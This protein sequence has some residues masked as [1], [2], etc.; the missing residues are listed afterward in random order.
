[1]PERPVLLIIS[2]SDLEFAVTAIDSGANDLLMSPFSSQEFCVRTGIRGQSA[3]RRIDTTH[4]VVPDSADGSRVHCEMPKIDPRTFRYSYG[5]PND[6]VSSWN[7]DELVT[8]TQ[9]DTVLVCPDCSGIPTFRHGCEA[10]GS[11]MTE[12]EAII[13]HYACAHI[14]AESTF[15]KGSSLSCPKCLQND[16]VAGSDFECVSGAHRCQD[17]NH[18]ANDPVLIGHCLSCQCRFPASEAISLPIIGYHVPAS[19]RQLRRNRRKT[20]VHAGADSTDS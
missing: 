13:H 14:G 4:P 8:A 10:C 7:R 17:C 3:R 1:M 12:P 6:V 18:V 2:D 19:R 11:A 20:S 9:L 5:V 15:R 16:L